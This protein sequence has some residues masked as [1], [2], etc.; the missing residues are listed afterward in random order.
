VL[1]IL[2]FLLCSLLVHFLLSV[3]CILLR[4]F[5]V[6]GVTPLPFSTPCSSR[7]FHPSVSSPSSP[8]SPLP[9]L[10][11]M[12]IVIFCFSLSLFCP[13]PFS[14]TRCSGSDDTSPSSSL[15]PLSHSEC[16]PLPPRGATSSVSSL[17]TMLT[18]MMLSVELSF[19]H[20][21]RVKWSSRCR[22]W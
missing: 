11:P 17:S 14:L 19:G 8:H 22:C 13:C 16:I 10:K 15:L 9:I 12:G 21:L 1:Y 5:P 3:I 18:S 7:P 2:S 6:P 4:V 20:L